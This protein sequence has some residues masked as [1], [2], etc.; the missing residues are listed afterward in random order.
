M[1]R[2]RAMSGTTA[3]L[4]QYSF[5]H[6][7]ARADDETLQ[8]LVGRHAVRLLDALDP[9]LTSPSRLREICLQ[10]HSP[11]ELLRDRKTRT[12]LLALLPR[13]QAQNLANLLSLGEPD[14]YTSLLTLKIRRE[15]NSERKLLDFLSV[16]PYVRP[17]PQK[18]DSISEVT[19]SYLLFDHQRSARRRVLGVLNGPRPRVVLH[20]PTGSGKTRTAMHIA[21]DILRQ[22]EPTVVVWLAY[23]EELCDQAASEFNRAWECLGDRQIN[24]HRYWG[25]TSDLSV[26][27][28]RDGFLVAG[29]GKMFE[30]ARRDGDFISRLADRSSLVIIDEAHQAI[31]PTY[32]FLLDYLVERRD[33]TGLLGLTAT[34]GRTWNDPAADLELAAFFRHQKVSLQVAGYDSPVEYLIENGYLACLHFRSMPYH[35]GGQLTARE[36]RNLSASLDVPVSILRR[37]AEDEKRNMIVVDAV[38]ELAGRHPRTLVFAATVD[39]ARLIATVLQARHID[40]VAITSDTPRDER[41]RTLAR[42]KSQSPEPM[43]LCNFGVLTTGFDAPRTSA[44]V[45]ARPT[46]SLVLYSQMIGRATRGPRAG[47]N[48]DAEVVSVVDST[49]PGFGELS[50][51]FSNWEDV[52]SE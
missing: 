46:K 47:G 30:R 38:E 43:V 24:V 49:L 32:Q 7:I 4:T 1:H 9:K 20:M 28:V 17:S 3:S 39:H 40:A 48:A 51:M 23:S 36:L 33:D 5:E 34:P 41:S 44:A 13:E 22:H 29:L 26:E 31:A 14:P 18:P 19:S 10:L 6:L 45:I 16:I 25:G 15:S 12:L 35:G 52:W 11:L 37:L 50:E 2:V 27:S 42:F 21:T 8:Q